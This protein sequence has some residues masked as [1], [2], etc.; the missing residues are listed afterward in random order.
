MVLMRLGDAVIDLGPLGGLQVHRSW[1]ANLAYVVH[2]EK[3][4]GLKTRDETGQTIP[5]GRN[6]RAALKD[7]MQ[8]QS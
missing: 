3:G 4:R 6:F 2:L 5:V 7:A 1:W 8:N